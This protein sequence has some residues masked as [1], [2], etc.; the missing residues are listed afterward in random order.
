[1]EITRIRELV[2]RLP[3]HERELCDRIFEFQASTAHPTLPQEM[4]AW[5]EETFGSVEAVRAQ[6]LLRAGNLVTGEETLFNPL[7]THRP[8]DSAGIDDLHHRI[9]RARTQDVFREPLTGTPQDSFGRVNGSHAVTAAN[10]N[11]YDA[12]HGVVIFKEFEPLTFSLAE[13]SDYLETALEWGRRA[14]RADHE[15]RYF[16]TI[17]NCLWRAGASLVHGHAQALLARGRH[18]GRVEAL[19]RAAEDY[20]SRYGSNYFTDLARVHLALGCGL[21]VDGVKVAAS[22]TPFKDRE[23][24]I[25]A[26]ALSDV[27][28]RVL[29]TVLATLVNDLGVNFF[30]LSLVIPPLAVTPES[31]QG[32]PVL[33]RLLDRGDVAN[34]TSDIGAMEI[35]AASVVTRDPFELAVCLRA[36]ISG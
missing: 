7:R 8:H 16:I 4:N 32:F 28:K 21:E 6:R 29:H 5:A 13:V 35:Y 2:T 11:P 10:I 34:R 18:Y 22:L 25:Y 23:V 1:M 12:W 24:M 19:R 36:A 17:W 27:F 33:V 30:N 9:E 26:D 3:A 31:W 20:R 15:A 14:H